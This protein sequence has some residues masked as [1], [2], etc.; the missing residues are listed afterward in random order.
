MREQYRPDLQCEK[1]N[2]TS[3]GGYFPYSADTENELI[4]LKEVVNN[5]N[6]GRALLPHTNTVLFMKFI[7]NTGEKNL[8]WSISFDT[9]V[10]E[11]K[12]GTLPTN[13]DELRQNLVKRLREC[14][15]DSEL[16]RSVELTPEDNFMLPY[17]TL[18]MK[19]KKN[20]HLR[21]KSLPETKFRVVLLGTVCCCI[22]VYLSVAVV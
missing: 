11:D 3:I 5:S 20:V 21:P 16:I 22:V 7:D 17:E 10:A 9:K 1:T 12:F 8:L 14:E 18:T 2:I 13:I 4:K 15:V 6:L 19:F